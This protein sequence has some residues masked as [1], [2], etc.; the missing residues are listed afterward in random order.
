MPSLIISS[1]SRSAPRIFIYHS[2]HIILIPFSFHSIILAFFHFSTHPFHHGALRDFLKTHFLLFHLSYPL[3]HYSILLSFLFQLHHLHHHSFLLFIPIRIHVLYSFIFIHSHPIL[4][5]IH[6]NHTYSYPFPFKSSHSISFHHSHSFPCSLLTP[7]SHSFSGIFALH[8]PSLT[9]V[10][11]I[12][13]LIPL[14]A[15]LHI[16]F[17]CC[18]DRKHS[19][20]LDVTASASDVWFESSGIEWWGNGR[21]R[22]WGLEGIGVLEAFFKPVDSIGW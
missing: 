7:H 14:S 22:T 5:L 12:P 6:F 19:H 9:L 4:P 13:I 20:H 18:V 11:S 15:I 2:S 17:I 16:P 21:M 10:S 1:A 3:I 8:Y